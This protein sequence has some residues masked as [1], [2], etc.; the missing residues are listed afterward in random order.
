M[1]AIDHAALPCF[2]VPATHRFYADVLGLPLVAAQRG[3]AEAWGAR[4][5]LLL[6]Y[7]L[8]D[9]SVLD[10]FTFDGIRRPSP[11]GL[12]KDIR[13]LALTVASRGEVRAL[14]KRLEQERVAFWTETHGADDVHV[15]VTDPGGIVLEIV[16]QEDSARQRE[17]DPVQ[18]N[19]VMAT[20]LTDHGAGP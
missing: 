5:F 12:P 2:D 11:D 4:E 3:P 10:L 15:Y 19:S 16:A 1:I 8:R 18:A 17:Q 14:A 7:R 13:H 20:W 9:G 6:A